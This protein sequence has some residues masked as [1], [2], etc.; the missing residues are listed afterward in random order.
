[1]G[2]DEGILLNEAKNE[3]SKT[4]NYPLPFPDEMEKGEG[5]AECRGGGR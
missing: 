1:M 4:Y 3:K 5:R 2:D